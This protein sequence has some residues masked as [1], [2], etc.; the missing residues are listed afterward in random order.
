MGGAVF[1]DLI[2]FNHENLKDWSLNDLSIVLKEKHDIAIR[3]QSLHDRFNQSAV[4]FLKEAI[5]RLLDKQLEVDPYL[6]SLEGINRILIKDSICFQ[7]IG[8]R[9]FS[10]KNSKC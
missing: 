9:D 2:V 5:E 7:I 1:L 8:V 10:S 3:K 4:L 6:L